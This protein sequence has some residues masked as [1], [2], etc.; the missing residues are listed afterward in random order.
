MGNTVQRNV[1]FL[2]RWIEIRISK[3]PLKASGEDLE[4]SD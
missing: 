4:G 2:N 1:A 3:T